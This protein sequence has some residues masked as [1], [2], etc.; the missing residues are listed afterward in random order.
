MSEAEYD[1]EP[2][3]V[4]V[5]GVRME[6]AQRFAHEAVVLAE[7]IRFH[8]IL[9]LIGKAVPQP[10]TAGDIESAVANAYRLAKEAAQCEPCAIVEGKHRAHQHDECIPSDGEEIV[11]RDP[12]GDPHD[13]CEDGYCEPFQNRTAS[14]PCPVS[15]LGDDVLNPG[16][17]ARYVGLIHEQLASQ[18]R[19]E[20]AYR[21]H[22]M[23]QRRTDGRRADW[24]DLTPNQKMQAR[25]AGTE[26]VPLTLEQR[27][28]TLEANMRALFDHQRNAPGWE[29]LR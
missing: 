13:C 14:D 17:L 8:A 12:E 24:D 22:L 19:D 1:R 6:Y 28:T 10:M 20:E 11:E 26:F 15:G 18:Q 4:E 29:D 9:D 16:P 2:S 21:Q 27:V 7:G 3:A 25:L 23:Q 5:G